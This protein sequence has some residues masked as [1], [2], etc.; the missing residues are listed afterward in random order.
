MGVPMR[1]LLCTEWGPPERLE[2]GERE[3]PHAGPGQVRI[4]VH[5]CGIN[6]ADTLIIQ[7]Q[8]QER[9]EF[10]FSPGLEVAGI[11][12]EAG[13]G[14]TEPAVGDR[15]IGICGHGGCAEEVLVPADATVAIP[16]SMEF[17]TAAGFTVAYGTAH[18]GLEH[19]AHLR[20][21]EVLLVH[22]ASG[23]V[24]LAAV[25]VGK[26][27]GATVIAT[28]SSAAKLELAARYGADHLINYAES[29][30]RDGVK[31]LTDGRGADVIFD[32]VGGEVF[33]QSMRCISWEGRLLVIG[34]ASGTIPK[35]PANL[36]LVKNCSVIGLYWGAYL[37]RQPETLKR[38]WQQ[39]LTWHDQGRLHPCISKTYPL[40]EAVAALRSIVDRTAT[41]KVVVQVQD[42]SPTTP[43]PRGRLETPA[44][45]A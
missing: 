9:P 26:L 12:L 16:D 44:P 31:E 6:F 45:V 4:A 22:G 29:E 40:E 10:P 8:Y 32:P 1:A 25:E 24:G 43:K 30:F 15:V 34:F 21:G 7:G 39:L 41:G 13:E 33:E 14:V 11:V 37:R 35:A 38:S 5:A 2:L 18:V 3:P 27:L 20:A 19:R 23:G 17:V 28:A 42:N 36:V